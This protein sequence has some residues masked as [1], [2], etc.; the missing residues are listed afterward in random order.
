MQHVIDFIFYRY[1][2]STCF[3]RQALIIKSPL[4]VYT[5]SNFLCCY[6]SAALSCKKLAFSGASDLT[7]RS[8]QTDAPLKASFLQDSVADRHQHRKLEAVCTV[9]GLLMMST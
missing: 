1:V 3:E 6:L 8:I 2:Y 5:A 4:T 7:N 9:K